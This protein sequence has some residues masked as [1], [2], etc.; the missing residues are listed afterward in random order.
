MHPLKMIT[1]LVHFRIY[2]SITDPKADTGN[3][4]HVY[5]FLR[6]AFRRYLRI[7]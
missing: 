3:E 4:T 5:A 7:F 2:N 6:L 1:V